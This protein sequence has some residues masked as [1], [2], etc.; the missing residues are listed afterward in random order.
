MEQS[1]EAR[2]R[3]DA[4]DAAAP[5]SAT[6]APGAL[7]A[8]P[9]DAVAIVGMAFRFPGDLTDE[10]ALWEALREG[11]DL[12]SEVPAD[13]WAT[14]ELQHPRRNEPGR[15]ITFAAGVVSD[16]EG[17][18][19]AFFG[20]SPREAAS[21]DPQQRL[22]LELVWEALENAGQRPSA[23][24]GSD[25]AVYVGLSSL[26]NGMRGLDDLANMSAHAMTGNTLS[27][28]ANRVSYFLDLRGPSLALDSACSSSLVALHQACNSLRCGEASSALVGGVN[29]LL[30]P[31]S[32]VGFTKASMLSAGGRC[33]AFDASGDGYVRAEGGVVLF[34]KRLRDALADGDPIQAVVRAS[35]TNTDGA[36]KTGITIPS[37]DG[38]VELMQRVL[39]RSGL[40]A[41][42]I[43][44]IE[45]HGTGTPVGDP[46][47][48]AAIGAVYGRPRAPLPP[49]PIGSVKTNL[50]HLEPVSGLAGLVKAVLA[51]KHRV[52]PGSL[53]LDTPNP[54]IDFSALHL[55]VA[56]RCMPLQRDDGRPLV[57]GVNSFGF[58][59]ANAHVLLQEHPV[60]ERRVETGARSVPQTVPPL[61]LSARSDE[62]LCALAQRYVAVLQD[63]TAETYRDIAC[64]AEQRRDR[65][66]RRLGLRGGEPVEMVWQ[67]TAF[68]RGDAADAVVV[69]DALPAPARIAFVYSGNGAQWAGMGRRLLEESPR[70][71]AL[72]QSLDETMRPAC[73]FSLIEEIRADVSRLDDTA[74]AQPLLFALQVVITTL[75]RDDGIEAA[76]VTGHSVGEVAAAWAAGALDLDQAIRV[77][78]ARS[79]AQAPTRG[80]GRMAAMALSEHAARAL[81][82][83]FEPAPDVGIAGIN[84]PS[85]VT[86]SGALD[87]LVAI[88]ARA[89]ARGVFF[90]LLD[91]DYAFHNRRMDTIEAP[92]RLRLDGLAPVSPADAPVLVSTVTGAVLQ[93]GALDAAYWWR[94]VREPVRF[95][96]AIATL[97]TLDCRILVEIGPNAILQRYIGECTSAAGASAR[98]LPTL[99]RHDDAPARIG[100]IALRALLLADALPR[101]GRLPQRGRHVRLPNYPWQRERHWQEKTSESHALASRRRVHPLLGWRLSEVEASWENTIDPDVLPWLSD[102]RVG[103][104]IVLPGTAYSELAL[105]AARTWRGTKYSA[106]EDLEILAPMVFD[107]E[108]SRTVRVSLDIGDGRIRITSRRRLST[109]AWTQHASARA[110]EAS[111][112]LHAARIAP[113]G[114]DAR[115][116]DRDTHYRLSATVGVDPGPAFRGLL[117]VRA[118]DDRLD[119][120]LDLPETVHSDP[121]YLLH[122]AMQD[123]CYQSVLA[124][125]RDDIENGRTDAMLPVRVG[126]IELQRDTP[127]VRCRARLLRRSERSLLVDFELFDA[128][129]DLVARLSGCR[130][131]SA[132]L[133]QRGRGG[134]RV[135]RIAPHLQP[136]PAQVAD[137]VL[138][139]TTDLLERLHARFADDAESRSR[140]AWFREGLPLF[141]ALALAI[142]H[143]TFGT[144][145]AQRPEWIQ[146][147]LCDPSAAPYLRWATARLRANALLDEHD[148]TWRLHHDE[149]MPPAAD[150]WRAL[151][152]SVPNGLPTLVPMARIAA[153]LP[154]LLDGSLD[155]VAFLHSLRHIPACEARHDDDP[156]YTGVFRALSATLRGLAEDVPAHRR[157]RVLE[158]ADGA[159][160]LPRAVLDVLPADRLDYVLAPLDDGARAR[161][162]AAYQDTANV[163]I[164][165]IAAADWTLAQRE[166]L[167]EV[168][169]VV[170]LRH[171]LHRAPN[172]AAA[173]AQAQRWLAPGGVLLLAERHPDWSADLLD[174]LDPA[175]WRGEHD[176]APRSSLCPPQIWREALHTA[177][178]DDSGCFEESTL[179]GAYLLLAKRPIR[180]AIEPLDAPA[181]RWCLLNDAASA[182]LAE[183]LR[184]RL[185]AR[186]QHVLVA[187]EAG[188]IGASDHVVHLRGWADDADVLVTMPADV[189]ALM[190]T[191]T[192]CPTPPRL[193]LVTRGGALC[194][195]LVDASTPHPAQTAVWGLGRVT[196]NESPALSCTLI[197]LV[198]DIDAD[199]LPLRLEH[200]LLQPDGANEIVLA[201]QARHVPVMREDTGPSAVAADAETPRY[202]L[203]VR[204]PGQ[205]RNLRWQ[206]FD[207]P[208]LRAD[209]IEVR[210]HAVGLN[211]RDVMYGMSLLPDEAVEN[212]FA[213]ATLGLEFAGVVTRI[214]D[215]VQTHA[216]GDAVLSFGP[217]CFASHVVTRADAA[218]AMPTGWSFESAATVPSV[219]LTAWYALKHLA[220]L[221]PGE[222]VLIHG[223]AG[224]VGIAAIQIARFL[225]AEVFATAGSEEKRDVA[226][227]LGAA[228]VFDSR[229]LDFADQVLAATGGEGVDAVLNSLAGEAVRRGL[230]VL[231][232]FGR[233]LELGKRDFFENTPIGLRPFKDNIQ[234]CGIDADRLLVDRPALA[235]TLLREVMA[236]FDDGTFVPLPYR[237][238][239]ADRIE[240]AFRTMQQSRH[241][242]KIV[243]SLRE[244]PRR[245]ES[246]PAAPPA[247]RFAS[248]S[249]WIVSGGLDG[250]GL[251]SAR[252]LAEHGVGQ[253]VLLGRRGLDTPGAPDAVEVLRANGTNVLALACDITDAAALAA[254]FA[255]VRDTLPPLKGILHA[256]MVID[257]GLLSDLDA[258]RVQ[259]VL[260]PKLLGAWH[261]HEGSR[262]LPLDHFVLY[263]SVTTLLGSPGQGSYIAANAGLEGL[264]ALRRSQ[265]LPATCVGWGPIG[266]AGFLARNESIRDGAA[267]RM[268]AAPLAAAQALEHLERL[269]FQDGGMRCVA[270]FD[271]GVLSRLLPSASGS[272]FAA[273]NADAADAAQPGTTEDF[274]SAIEGKS[275]AQVLDIVRLL[276]RQ[277]VA[278]ILCIA[279]ERIEPR[280]ALHDLGMDS[281]MAVELALG[282]ERRFGVQLPVMALNDAP[283]VERISQ[284]VVDLV[285]GGDTSTPASAAPPI[286]A[287]VE[288]FA[289]QHGEIATPEEI[290]VL[291]GDTRDL[292]RTG[293]R[294]IA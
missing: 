217:Q 12:V 69:E 125:F 234:Y 167:P 198:G 171:V 272:R 74:V 45:A 132:S 184:E 270:G 239:E 11:R 7:P 173:L 204:T 265:G 244:L 104:A 131:R 64:A 190:Q 294:L 92:L 60:V 1:D 31:Y 8:L 59:G 93:G 102:H 14:A 150:I 212:G 46:I 114:E 191:L 233:F 9:P 187:S 269:L 164:A 264:A 223:A 284:R 175:W 58:G 288:H 290:D 267:R 90:R 10:T 42:D 111:Q 247:R 207:T 282:L 261:L 26:D 75:L 206:R 147:T 168:F 243:V 43:D 66:E 162:R 292:V 218:V 260:R 146:A 154:D 258:A 142:L 211:F 116:L 133:L 94:N 182:D 242:G 268:G 219:F 202:R 105:A 172:P 67:L 163:L 177:Q 193:W 278:Q 129:G 34:L 293:A 77:V 205:L 107:T 199:D 279:P 248:D 238:F 99:R 254:V 20:I 79:A 179:G 231:R 196:M 255:T 65:M 62:A 89:E 228:H 44:F 101:D 141:E 103:G 127:V 221:Q 220:N 35:G 123:A 222:R 4:G 139:G 287:V 51:L 56:T 153:A 237:R 100:D 225:G 108:Q 283:S 85:Q 230:Q 232:P 259:R 143:D 275:A 161:Q 157:L 158:L 138:P 253:L 227:L 137:A 246:K 29:L 274:R 216:P 130:F 41:R 86:L 281:L 15:S 151:L 186:G 88:G 55:A 120:E 165:D 109:D 200:E 273:L 91:L 68:A 170:V 224:G 70:A 82:A 194:D 71:A 21:L 156:A 118:G 252:W 188:A 203:D 169:D 106:V 181:A 136:H 152:H 78:C 155:A 134:P 48:A 24:A 40:T 180:A 37:H 276:V 235:A 226:R 159:S 95:A 50:G 183:R 117:Q 286:D 266:D 57:A 176:G 160:A 39:A 121:G 36:R 144:L 257:D 271:W 148:G 229:R 87:D 98:V 27:I 38:Q 96:D 122:P 256:A 72:L 291:A 53:H 185:H 19:A 23:L 110:I 112:H 213:G 81:L 241:I 124:F 126:R 197:D 209:E 263:S 250:F 277:D 49:L 285:L 140:G 280:R 18:D 33:R 84:S 47:E 83:E 54:H 115:L 80:S 262:D 201:T 214:G 17:F 16:L 215:G 3:R 28:V 289:R 22:M 240:D 25:C 192:A 5:S 135:W 251:A 52:L 210:P 2:D 166:S 174:G 236:K 208:P 189:V 13:R 97:L 128:Q 195:G 61:L 249:T 145:F 6:F 245:I 149:D 63:A 178:F 119:A 30:H 32:F 113:V 73:G 76:A